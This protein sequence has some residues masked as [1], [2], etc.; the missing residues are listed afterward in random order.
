MMDN[1]IQT[2][3]MQ[4]ESDF[5]MS[6]V[7]KVALIEACL[8]D[9]QMLEDDTQKLRMLQNYAKELY[10]MGRNKDAR[11]IALDVYHKTEKLHIDEIH[12][13]ICNVLGNLEA[14]EGDYALALDYYHQSLNMIEVNGY[15]TQFLSKLISNMAS[16]YAALNMFDYAVKYYHEALS[17]GEKEANKDS[18]FLVYYNL[19]DIYSKQVNLEALDEMIMQMKKMLETTS[20][21]FINQGL[22]YL[23]LIKC[24]RSNKAFEQAFDALDKIDALHLE[25]DD[26]ITVLE[27]AIER[28]RCHQLQ[29]EYTLAL[30]YGEKA[31]EMVLKTGEFEFER[32]ILLLLCDITKALD[33]KE[34][35]I[36]YY[37]KLFKI[38]DVLMKKMNELAIY[39][40]RE[41]TALTLDAKLNNNT[42]RL[43]KNMR[44][45]YDISH[46]ITKEQDYDMLF[47]LIIEKLISFL[48]FDA[49]VIGLYNKDDGLIYNRMMYHK[50]HISKSFDVV[51]TN[52][53]SLAAWCIRHNQEVY[54]NTNSQLSLE[55]FEPIH[56][57]FPD[58]Q[59]PYESVYYIPLYNENEII[60]VF[61]LQKYEANAF[62][63]YELE[64]IRAISSYIAI[65]FTNAQK[66]DEMRKLN[67]A[68]VTMSRQDALSGLLNRN[69]LNEDIEL[70]IKRRQET[71]EPMTLLM[72]DID[73]FKEYND[74]YG[75]LEGDH[76]ICEVASAIKEMFKSYKSSVYRYGGDEILI[77]LH[78]LER[79]D[80]ARLSHQLLQKIRDVKMP[81]A[82]GIDNIVTL[83]IGVVTFDGNR[84][85]VGE[86]ELL[87][88]AD[89]ALYMAKRAG[90]NQ[91]SIGWIKND[92]KVDKSI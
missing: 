23:S 28:A 11:K 30:V 41:K 40:I 56:I 65:A 57:N 32:D 87:K 18:L 83:S 79:K 25:I 6:H 16:I 60:G 14:R 19:A 20:Q 55:D 91:V 90:R 2:L 15:R 45:I 12:M 64:M 75:H 85:I 37:E 49:L 67:E 39:Q 24:H 3:N 4:I 29:G 47:K 42:E 58:L 26:P 76:I 5:S 54:S 63:H 80:A 44:F 92:K 66:T 70:F 81:H 78:Q 17:I 9:V 82:L 27:C 31:Y 51:V 88:D 1:K 7:S 46:E 38:D 61:S 62:D 59:V 22:Y 73:Y 34:R 71:L 13:K 74:F 48:T 8:Q 68:L 21:S 35:L 50:G 84:W 53:S 72:C 10:A 86:D 52:K 69:A 36:T 89:H 33:D 77:I 43:L